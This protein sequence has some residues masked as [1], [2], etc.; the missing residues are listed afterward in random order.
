MILFVNKTNI[1]NRDFYYILFFNILI[2]GVLYSF[3]VIGIIPAGDSFMFERLFNYSIIF[4]PILA[5]IT[6]TYFSRNNITKILIVII[7]LL[8]SI[9]SIVNLVPSP[10]TYK[11]GG[12]SGISG[13]KGIRY[14]ANHKVPELNTFVLLSSPGRSLRGMF[15]RSFLS[16]H[17][18]R[19]FV[20]LPDHFGYDVNST[21]S[22]LQPEGGYI[23]YTDMDYFVYN[24]V[25][26]P[27]GRFLYSDFNKLY[28]DV[29]VNKC[30]TNN[31]IVYMYIN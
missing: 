31:N 5:G 19:N 17:R 1:K 26:S 16:S 9:N 11:P 10:L 12:G 2:F 23:Y 25:Y 6:L 3:S 28:N 15:N 13:N 30:Y 22:L 21:L 14:F 18:L 4:S 29:S 24:T 8:T 27:V 20:N 7:L